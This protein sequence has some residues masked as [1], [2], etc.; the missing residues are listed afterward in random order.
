MILLIRSEIRTVLGLNLVFGGFPLSIDHI[1]RFSGH[2]FIQ[3]L[4]FAQKNGLLFFQNVRKV[5]NSQITL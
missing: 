2:V 1:R 3:I 5:N 4:E